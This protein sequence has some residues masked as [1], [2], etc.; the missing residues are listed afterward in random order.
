MPN[1]KVI[2]F[3]VLQCPV[4]RAEGASLTRWSAKPKYSITSGDTLQVRERAVH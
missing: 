1:G 3:P 2:S 4:K